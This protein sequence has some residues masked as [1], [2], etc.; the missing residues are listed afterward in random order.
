MKQFLFVWVLIFAI[1]TEAQD[2]SVSAIPQSLKEEAYAVVRLENEHVDFYD[3]NKVKYSSEK[4][5]TILNASA[6]PY[7]Y[8]QLGYNK[9]RKINKFEASLYDANGKLMRKLGRK[10]L[11]DV[12]AF[13]GFSLYI[14]TRIQYFE[15][16]PTSYPFTI[17]YYFEY[18][19]SNTINLP[20][21]NPIMHYNVGIE[22][23]MY[24]LTNHSTIP[25]RKKEYGFDFLDVSK[26]ESGNVLNYS[27]SHIQPMNEEV[28]S[29]ALS[30]LT[31]N[32]FFSPTEFQLEGVKG[33]ME[34]WKDFGKWYYENL[35]KDKLDLSETDKQNALKLVDGI[36]DPI[37]KVRL[38]YEYMQ[39]KTRYVNI[40]IGIGGWEPFPASYVSSKSYGDCKAL[41]NYMVSLLEV[42]GIDAFHTIVYADRKRK[43]NI[44]DDFTSLQG[45]H[46]IVNVPMD[47]ETLWLECTS[48]QTAFNYLG[49]FTDD[50]YVLSVTP[51]GG[52]IISTKNYPAEVNKEIIQIKGEI[53]P[54]GTLNAKYNIKH[55]GL[56]YDRFSSLAFMATNQQKHN[57]NDLFGRLPNLKI[58]NYS[59]DND[60]KNAIFKMNVDLESSQYAKRIGDN[61]V[62]NVISFEG[63]GS[64]LKKDNHRKYPFEVRYGYAD[65]TN[66]ELKIPK[67]FAM[68]SKFQPLIYINEFGSYFLSVEQRDD[69]TLRI[70]RKLVVNDGSYPKEKFNDYVEFQRII[71]SM[72]NTKILIEKK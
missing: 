51:E 67:G 6:L 70:V 66:F 58:E 22:K 16:T 19:L 62:F 9:S 31:P 10:D 41:S 63:F 69:Q 15:F 8:Q 61:L 71:S 65:E 27:A 48:Q 46:M 35:I 52:E 47:G 38:L 33:K 30:E 32:V 43:V 20:S 12:S 55:S 24:S 72:D 3:Y 57:L 1:N 53:L 26:I 34:D 45:N 2:Y 25:I 4:V 56:Q 54:N 28:L 59:L 39:A 64:N 11:K 37:E 7:A 60:R 36:E 49:K 68:N 29:P 50:R 14:D 5:I 21:W 40:S 17:R 23:S 18:N 42:V 13:D 44:K